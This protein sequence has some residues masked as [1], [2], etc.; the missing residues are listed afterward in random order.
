MLK[1]D[2]VIYYKIK[3]QYYQIMKFS[4]IRPE[5]YHIRIKMLT[6]TTRPALTFVLLNYYFVSIFRQLKLELLIIRNF[7]L[8][9]TENIYIVFNTHLPD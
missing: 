1:C 2:T 7:Q 3:V 8:Q 5:D 6:F 4:M 9:F